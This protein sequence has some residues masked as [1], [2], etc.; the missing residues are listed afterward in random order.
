[1]VVVVSWRLVVVRSVKQE[2]DGIVV[3][4][5]VATDRALTD[6]KMAVKGSTS[7]TLIPIFRRGATHRSRRFVI[8]PPLTLALMA[9]FL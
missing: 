4:V 2:I 5:L 6:I 7:L 3:I 1:M 8:D 9:L